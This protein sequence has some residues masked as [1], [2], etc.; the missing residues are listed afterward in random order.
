MTQDQIAIT[1]FVLF[2]LFVAFRVIKSKIEYKRMMAER[3]AAWAADYH[4][5]ASP[6]YDAARVL[7]EQAAQAAADAEAEDQ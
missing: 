1:C 6:N 7:L 5:P 3:E 2:G 4:N